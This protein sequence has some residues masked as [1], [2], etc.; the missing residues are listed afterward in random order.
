MQIR[1]HAKHPRDGR[2]FKITMVHFPDGRASDFAR[3]VRSLTKAAYGGVLE[4]L[5][6]KGQPEATAGSFLRHH[7]RQRLRRIPSLRHQVRFQCARYQQA[8]DRFGNFLSLYASVYAAQTFGWL[9]STALL[10]AP[11]EEKPT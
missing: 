8:G 9:P 3:S 11:D 7:V 6:T 5:V 4:E 2:S 10:Q 1:I